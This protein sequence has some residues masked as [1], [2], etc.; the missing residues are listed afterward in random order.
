MTFET[1]ISVEQKSAEIQKSIELKN[2]LTENI[3]NHLP[4]ELGTDKTEEVLFQTDSRQDYLLIE[5]YPFD[6]FN[7]D[8]NLLKRDLDLI[9]A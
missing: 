7:R 4:S 9:K 5:L 2:E 3:L 6:F 1:Q 8:Y